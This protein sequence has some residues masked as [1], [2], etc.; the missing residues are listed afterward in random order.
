M[1][2]GGLLSLARVGQW[3]L[4]WAIRRALEDGTYDLDARTDRVV[5]AL[6]RELCGPLAAR[7]KHA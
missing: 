5:S 4:V 2:A 6:M 7:Q 1:G 3:A